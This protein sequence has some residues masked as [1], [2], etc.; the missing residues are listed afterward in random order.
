MVFKSLSQM[1]DISIKCNQNM[2]DEDETVHHSDL[3]HLD[4]YCLEH[5][6]IMHLFE[7]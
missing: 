5:I 7:G 2:V 6:I 3:S 4:L 1:N